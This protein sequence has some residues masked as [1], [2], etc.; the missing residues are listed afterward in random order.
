[1]D[2]TQRYFCTVYIYIGM[3]RVGVWVETSSSALSCAIVRMEFCK[4]VVPHRHVHVTANMHSLWLLRSCFRGRLYDC[5]QVLVKAQPHDIIEI[6]L[7]ISTLHIR[8]DRIS[9]STIVCFPVI[10]SVSRTS[11]QS[12]ELP[13]QNLLVLK[14]APIRLKPEA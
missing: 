13:L 14:L 10:P 7:I 2:Y 5:L 9:C 1:M 3:E 4:V 11:G 12:R 8:S 6:S